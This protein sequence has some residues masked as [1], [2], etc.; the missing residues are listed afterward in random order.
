MQNLV[1]SH[2]QVSIDSVRAAAATEPGAFD[3]TEEEGLARPAEVI[4]LAVA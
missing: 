2:Q 1:R 3:L 4:C